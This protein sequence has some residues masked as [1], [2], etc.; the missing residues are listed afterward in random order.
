MGPGRGTQQRK[1]RAFRDSSKELLCE[2]GNLGRVTRVHAAWRGMKASSDG[3]GVGE[4]ARRRAEG[5]S[6][7]ETAGCFLS[8]WP[9]SHPR[10]GSRE[11]SS[12]E[13]FRQAAWR[14][15][16]VWTPLQRTQGSSATPLPYLP[17]WIQGPKSSLR[18]RMEGGLRHKPRCPPAPCP[19]LPCP[20]VCLPAPPHACPLSRRL[21]PL[22]HSWP[23]SPP[24]CEV[25][26]SHPVEREPE[27]YWDPLSPPPLLPTTS[28][29]WGL[30]TSL[31]PPPRAS[32]RLPES[33][34][35]PSL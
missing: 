15:V 32:K 8:C 24:P 7:P 1:T 12:R 27:T 26:Q 5:R 18:T 35:L 34:A 16:G 17:V 23:L 30:E 33:S 3:G 25:P 9:A 4:R 14:G 19:D 6:G 20:G 31:P 10:Q 22:S 29:M 21:L 11:C 28:S 13:K 2:R